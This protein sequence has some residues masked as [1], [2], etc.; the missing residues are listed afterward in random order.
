MVMKGDMLAT[1]P[2]YTPLHRAGQ[3]LSSLPANH[4]VKFPFQ[5]LSSLGR[6]KKAV[7]SLRPTTMVSGKCFNILVGISATGLNAAI[8]I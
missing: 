6:T 4:N 3:Y 5:L 1:V 2:G 7:K 8:L